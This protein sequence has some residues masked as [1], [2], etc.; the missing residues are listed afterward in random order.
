MNL[1]RNVNNNMACLQKPVGSIA[2]RD[3]GRIH[4][5]L[6]VAMMQDFSVYIIANEL[7][8]SYVNKSKLIMQSLYL[9]RQYGMRESKDV[10]VEGRVQSDLLQVLI[11]YFT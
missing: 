3:I 4:C 1:F 9:S 10:T 11:Y 8:F 6:Q 7:V 2:P 5:Y